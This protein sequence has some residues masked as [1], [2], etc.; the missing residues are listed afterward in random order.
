VPVHHISVEQASH[1]LAE[2]GFDLVDVRELFEWA[3]G[4]LPGARHVPL[5]RLLRHPAS[6]LP[7]DRVIFVCGHGMRSLTAAA[8]ALSLGLSEIYSIDG[9]TEHWASRGF[10]LERD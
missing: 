4:H 10:P 3:T 9:G 7:R 8:V 2:G 5:E 1:M 6:H